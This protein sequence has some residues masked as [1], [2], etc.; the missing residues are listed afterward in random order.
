ME[1]DPQAHVAGHIAETMRRY[2]A[3]YQPQWDQN[4]AW[5]EPLQDFDLYIDDIPG[6]VS[7]GGLLELSAACSAF[8]LQA[9]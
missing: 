7:Q 6:R 8:R 9:L 5:G 3:W 4:T 1:G 2:K